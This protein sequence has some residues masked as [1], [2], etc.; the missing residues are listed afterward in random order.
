MEVRSARLRMFSAKLKPSPVWK[1]REVS[2]G[3]SKC[4]LLVPWTCA[5]KRGERKGDA[6]EEW[7]VVGDD[8]DKDKPRLLTVGGEIA[9]ATEGLPLE[10]P[11]PDLTSRRA[12]APKLSRLAKGVAGLLPEFV[13]PD[14]A[15]SSSKGL[16]STVAEVGLEMLSPRGRT[17]LKG[18]FWLVEPDKP[19]VVSE[20]RR[21]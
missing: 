6:C 19:I 11:L 12:R 14:G 1:S 10:F 17:V 5:G 15:G 9:L 21:R 4:V 13:E 20:S 2:S 7:I 16:S 18:E 8:D 3:I